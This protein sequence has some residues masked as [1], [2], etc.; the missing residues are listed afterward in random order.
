MPKSVVAKAAFGFR[1]DIAVEDEV[2]I[3]ADYGDGVTGVFVTATHDPA[4]T[5]RLEILGDRGKIVV[6]DSRIATLTRF[7]AD[8]REL[9]ASLSVEEGFALAS[10]A[11]TSEFSTTEEITT[12]SAWGAQHAGVLANFAAAILHGPELLAPGAD[13]INGVRLAN[14]AHLSAWLGEEVSTDI[15]EAASPRGLNARTRAEGA[16]PEWPEP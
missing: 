5:D 16:C 6:T 7:T 9:S 8:E 1:R 13:G 3:L 12:E 11:Q 4:G 14:A 2:T 15:A 10:G